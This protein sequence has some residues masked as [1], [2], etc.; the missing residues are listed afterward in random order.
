MTNRADAYGAFGIG[1]TPVFHARPHR[2]VS[3]VEFAT[4]G[5]ADWYNTR[6]L[7]SSLGYVPPAEFEHPHYA[8]LTREPQPA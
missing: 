8:T 7:H 5:W 4:A 1:L 2:T 6:R 3:D